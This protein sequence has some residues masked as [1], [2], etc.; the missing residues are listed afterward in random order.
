MQKLFAA[1]WLQC[2]PLRLSR[3][4]IL[5][6]KQNQIIDNSAGGRCDDGSDIQVDL[7]VVGPW[8]RA[9]SRETN[10]PEGAVL[11]GPK[12]QRYQKALGRPRP[13]GP[14]FLPNLQVS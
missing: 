12:R 1:V 6:T 8:P 14:L 3:L 2:T 4:S 9:F 13:F 7:W 10:L 11:T 5:A